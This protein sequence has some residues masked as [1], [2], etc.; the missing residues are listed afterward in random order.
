MCLIGEV[1]PAKASGG[2][3]GVGVEWGG[4]ELVATL[5]VHRTVNDSISLQKTRKCSSCRRLKHWTT[6]KC[7]VIMEELKT[8]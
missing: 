6:L 5:T 8:S 3:T 2:S 7:V 4:G 1:N